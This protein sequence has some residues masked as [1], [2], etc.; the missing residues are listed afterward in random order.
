MIVQEVQL[1]NDTKNLLVP[2][3][4]LA[5][6]NS[7]VTA[8]VEGLVTKIKKPLGSAVKA[9]EVVL[10]VENKDPTFTYAAVPVRAPVTGVISQIQPTLMSRVSRGEKLFTVMD[11][12]ALKLAAE[13]PGADLGLIQPG[14]QGIFKQDLDAEAGANIRVSGISPMVDPRTGTASA[15]LEFSGKKEALPAVGAV[16]HALFTLTRGKVLLIPESA[17][18]YSEGKPVVK[19]IDAA[20]AVKRKTVELGEQKE[21]LL[22]IKAGLEAGEKLIVRSNRTLK[23][24]ESVDVESSASAGN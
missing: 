11:P 18:G 16:G 14:S 12:K 1:T 17:L 10:Y 15:E 13:I 4:V 21:S 3:K 5:K 9:G 20:G 24:G 23:D 2:A 7:T 19:V 22:V 8:E 6:V